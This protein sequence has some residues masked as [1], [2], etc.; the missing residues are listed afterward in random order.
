MKFFLSLLLL[1]LFSQNQ[2]AQNWLITQ[3]EWGGTDST[4]TS[5][6]HQISYITIHHGGEIFP[7]DINTVTYLQGLQKWSRSDRKWNDIPYH[8]VVARDGKI[9][10][11]RPLNY[12]GDTNTTYDP[13]GHALIVLLGNF[14]EQELNP[15]QI[16]SLKTVT[17]YLAKQ[18]S[19]AADK[20]KTHKDYAETLCPGVKLSAYLGTD[21]WNRFLSNISDQ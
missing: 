19:V 18:E 5:L 15:E 11:G 21:D 6:E 1:F 17:S 8:Y 2:I 14:E 20:I 16:E 3:E 12:R 9:Y 4:D 10:E 7:E 13:T